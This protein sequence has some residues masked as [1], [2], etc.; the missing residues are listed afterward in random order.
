MTANG[1]QESLTAARAFAGR[2]LSLPDADAAR[3]AFDDFHALPQ[4]V[5]QRVW[6][7]I[8]YRKAHGKLNRDERASLELMSAEV[9][10]R[11]DHLER[12]AVRTRRPIGLVRTEE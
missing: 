12:E 4:D 9:A 10:L 11:T 6:H 2:I 5:L 7:I 3:S 8:S 1:S